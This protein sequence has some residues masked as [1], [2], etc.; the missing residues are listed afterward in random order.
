MGACFFG[1]AEWAALRLQG[2]ASDPKGGPV[3][4]RF[5]ALLHANGDGFQVID[6]YRFNRFFYM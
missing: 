5:A 3:Y 6:Y 1:E 4:K 2:V